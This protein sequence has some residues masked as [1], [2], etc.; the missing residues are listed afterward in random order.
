M[1]KGD[2][3]PRPGEHRLISH[4]RRSLAGPE[5]N[6]RPFCDTL[7][8]LS[9]EIEREGAIQTLRV[10]PVYDQADWLAA[11]SDLDVK[12]AAVIDWQRKIVQNS[13]D[14]NYDSALMQLDQ[15]FVSPMLEE[16]NLQGTVRELLP[17][18]EEFVPLI[19]EE[20]PL[21]LRG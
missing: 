9:A 18:Y 16:L 19:K 11:K 20:I 15:E 2:F 21:G 3:E 4:L 14:R 5:Y 1:W 8:Y 7:R 12:T 17:V 10:T 6:V 13:L